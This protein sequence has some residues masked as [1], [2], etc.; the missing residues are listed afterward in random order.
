MPDAEE[1]ISYRIPVFK[2]HGVLV[3]FAAFK[4]HIGIYPPVRGDAGLERAI[5]R[6][7]GAKGN[8]QFPLDEPIPYA[9]IARIAKQGEAEPRK[10]TREVRREGPSMSRRDDPL[11]VRLGDGYGCTDFDA[12]A[13]YEA[14]DTQR[15]QRGALRDRHDAGDAHRRVDR[16]ARGDVPLR[17]PMVS[18]SS[19]HDRWR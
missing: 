4:N 3:Y 1:A 17:G 8:L 18:R 7:A 9:L 13:L 6:Y 5:A 11:E 19:A 14:M 15:T 10:G 12:I 2:R 16:A